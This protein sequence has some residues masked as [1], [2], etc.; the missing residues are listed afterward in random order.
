MASFVANASMNQKM[1]IRMNS[2]PSDEARAAVVPIGLNTAQI[3]PMR[4]K[5]PNRIHTHFQPGTAEATKN[6]SMP[7]K[8]SMKPTR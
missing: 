3:P 8:I 5:T 4:K 6:C 1:A 7:V 2:R